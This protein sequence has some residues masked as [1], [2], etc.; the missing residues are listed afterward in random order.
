MIAALVHLG[1]VAIRSYLRHGALP[2]AAPVERRD[3][4]WIPRSD[5]RTPGQQMVIVLCR[6][7]KQRV[8][9]DGVCYTLPG[10]V[11]H[12]LVRCG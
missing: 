1:M 9:N 7:D 10:G 8:P 2:T 12:P 5:R 3:I 11:V 6:I 4:F